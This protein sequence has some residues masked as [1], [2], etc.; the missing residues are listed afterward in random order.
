VLVGFYV[1]QNRSLVTDVW[2]LLIGSICKGEAV[3][4]ECREHF[5]VLPKV[6]YCA[7]ETARTI[8]G[9]SY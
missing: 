8:L 2:G 4:E 6:H 3:K 9:E 1:A 7:T 5:F